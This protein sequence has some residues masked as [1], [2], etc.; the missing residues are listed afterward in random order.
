V[1]SVRLE[2]GKG[3]AKGG[4]VKRG[5]ERG[6]TCKRQGETPPACRDAGFG[7][8]GSKRSGLGHEVKSEPPGRA[9]GESRS[10]GGGSLPE[11]LS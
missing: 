9:G 7:E 8:G 10:R 5:G 4:W 11:R 6:N 1:L 2:G 3:R